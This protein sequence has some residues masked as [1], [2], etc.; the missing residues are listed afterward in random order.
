MP[1]RTTLTDAEAAFIQAQRVGRLATSDAEGRPHV[2]PVC[3]AFDGSRFYTPLDEK[4]KRV[5][6]R[7]LQRVRNIEVRPDVALLV[8]RYD[9][10]WSHLGYVLVHGHASLIGPENPAHA[11]ALAQLRRR[12]PQYRAMA[13]ETRPV[14]AIDPDSVTSWGPEISS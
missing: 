12:Y 9:D 3:Y 2:V 5:A 4:P 10:D 11:G 7:S 13:L 6:D 8:D 1:R 14:I